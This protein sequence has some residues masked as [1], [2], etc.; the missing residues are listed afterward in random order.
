MNA[1][2]KVKLTCALASVPL[3]ISLANTSLAKL[4][5]LSLFNLP[6]ASDSTLL[7]TN[8]PTFH[9]SDEQTQITSENQRKIDQERREAVAWRDISGICGCIGIPGLLFIIAAYKF[10]CLEDAAIAEKRSRGDGGIWGIK[11]NDY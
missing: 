6:T 8:N 3:V 7:K 1:E 10:A 11:H 9:L 4:P 2:V 5:D